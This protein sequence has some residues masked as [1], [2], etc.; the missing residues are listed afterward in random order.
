MVKSIMRK[1]ITCSVADSITQVSEL[2]IKKEINHIS[3]LAKDEL[4]GIVT[5]WDIAKAIALN[6]KNLKEIM[7]RKVITVYEEEAAE[8]AAR[9]LREYRISGLP[10]LDRNNKLIGLVTSENISAIFSVRS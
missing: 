7:T 4:V 2:L 9:K 8:E 6:E 10:V 3:V 5:S 1:P